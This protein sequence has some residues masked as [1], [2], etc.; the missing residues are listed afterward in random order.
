MTPD[1]MW[2]VITAACWTLTFLTGGLFVD[3][4]RRHIGLWSALK[5]WATSSI[6]MMVAAGLSAFAITL[7][8]SPEKL[9]S[10]TPTNT[11]S[12]S[13]QIQINRE[14]FAEM[15]QLTGTND[16]PYTCPV[17]LSGSA[18]LYFRAYYLHEYPRG[19]RYVFQA[20]PQSWTDV[21]GITGVR[22]KPVAFEWYA[23]PDGVSPS[24]GWELLARCGTVPDLV[25]PRIFSHGFEGGSTKGWSNVVGGG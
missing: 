15:T 21:V 8:V 2:Q 12:V 23:R 10:E 24:P 20:A 16:P 3:H 9:F 13:V 4:L 22:G 11:S 5:E 18:E 1:E 19:E 17:T 6:I 14:P 25:F 7:I